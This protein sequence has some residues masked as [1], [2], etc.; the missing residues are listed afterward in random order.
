MVPGLVASKHP[1]FCFEIRFGGENYRKYF[2]K[3]FENKT[4]RIFKVKPAEAAGAA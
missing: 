3:V 1:R 2:K 4:F